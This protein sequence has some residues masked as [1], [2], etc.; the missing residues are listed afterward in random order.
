VVAVTD[1]DRARLDRAQ[2]LAPDAKCFQEFDALLADDL[3]EAVY[4]ATPNFLHAEQTVKAATAGKHV[5]CEKPMALSASEAEVMVAASERA[6]VKLM[7]AYMSLFNPA[8]LAA[9]RVVA[10]GRLG[11][12]V[13]T[14]GR[15]SYP[16]A[17]LNISAAA[18]WRL[19]PAHGGGPL[20]DVAVYPVATLRE[21]TG[22]QIVRIQ[23]VGSTRLLRGLTNWDSIAVACL[24]DDDTP[25]VI[26]A[27]FTYSSSLI[28][29]EGTEGRLSLSGHI[30][31]S[32]AGRLEVEFWGRDSGRTGERL[33]HE[34]VPDA[35]PH[36]G[37]YLNEVEHFAQCVFEDSEPVASGRIA[38]AD[39]KV[40]D[41]IR[42]SIE[43]QTAVSLLP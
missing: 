1:T 42:I 18:A 19:N 8:Y 40:V 20:L 14:R 10:D 31:Q 25:A 5:L 24:L 41:A 43:E 2:Q 7:V 22:R 28:E 21:I 29:L 30:S 38:L 3:V 26:E 23:A 9:K 27:G 34:L 32:V 4:I 36:F 35:L 13:S 12:V 17:P 11:E 6:G 39:M 16:I 33:V 15:H 37:N